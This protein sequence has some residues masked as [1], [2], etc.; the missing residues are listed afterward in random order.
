MHFWETAINFLIVNVAVRLALRGFS[1]TM[2][3]VRIEKEDDTN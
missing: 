2:S 1:E 3:Q